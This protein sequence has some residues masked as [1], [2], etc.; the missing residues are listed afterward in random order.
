[1]TATII[2]GG[3]IGIYALSVIV[4]KVRRVRK[5]QYCD[6]GCGQCG[7]G[8]KAKTGRAKKATDDQTG[9]G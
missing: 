6:C 8:C 5:G 4:Q 2:I 7:A 3:V 9:S 1:M